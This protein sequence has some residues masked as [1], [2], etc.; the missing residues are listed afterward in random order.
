[1]R[2]LVKKIIIIYIIRYPTLGFL[3]TITIYKSNSNTV[4]FQAMNILFENCIQNSLGIDV[5]C[6]NSSEIGYVF[7]E[8]CMITVTE[9][10]HRIPNESMFLFCFSFSAKSK[11]KYQAI[12]LNG[13][14][15]MCHCPL[16]YTAIYKQISRYWKYCRISFKSQINICQF[17]VFVLKPETYLYRKYNWRRNWYV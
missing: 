10:K 15:I 9:V 7:L 1:M 12:T 13:K 11:K 6:F 17:L 2:D 4:P 8:A 14:W 3:I 16:K 5:F